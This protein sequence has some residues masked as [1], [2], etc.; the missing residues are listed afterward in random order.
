[1]NITACY[2]KMDKKSKKKTNKKALKDER[3]PKWF[4]FL[5]NY[6]YFVYIF[7]GNNFNIVT[8]TVDK[9]SSSAY[10]Y[11]ANIV[12]HHSKFNLILFVLPVYEK[13]SH[14]Y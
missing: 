10:I 9:C 1:M 3:M 8:I 6:S 14:C 7:K 11:H 4:L 13:I 2:I 12:F 5:N